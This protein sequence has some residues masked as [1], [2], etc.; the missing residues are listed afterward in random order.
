MAIFSLIL[1]VV[2]LLLMFPPSSS[3]SDVITHDHPLPDGR[4][5]V[6]K[7][8][9]FE[10]G[11]FS[12]GSST[13]RYV[14]IWYKSI[15][16]KTVVWVANRE[17]PV[18]DNSSVLS[19]NTEGRLVLLSQNQTIVWSANSTIQ[20][21]N[22][23]AQL[24][25][26]GNLVLRNEQDQNPQNYLWQS[27]DYP[28]D[29]FLPGMKIG[30]DLKTGLNRRLIA[31]RNWDD[32]SPGDFTCGIA[33]HATPELVMWNGSEEIQ[34]SSPWNGVRIGGKTTPLFQLQF[35]V[36][37]DEVVY[38]SN[39]QGKSVTTRVILNQTVYSR[40]RYIWVEQTKSWMIYSSVP[41]DKC[42]DYN[43]CGPNGNCIA[44]ESPRCQC[45]T[46]F[47]PKSPKKYDALDWTQGCVR[48][49]P[50][51]C[52]VKD[53]DGF[54]KFSGLKLPDTRTSWVNA[55]MTLWECKAKCWEICSCNAYAN[56]YITGGG[57]GCILWFGDL[58][59]LRVVTVPGQD[60]FIR[61]A[62]SDIVLE[63]AEKH[64]KKVVVVTT[65]TFT[66]VLLMLLAFFSIHRRNRKRREK[67][68]T[69]DGQEGEQ[70]DIELPFFDIA[71]IIRV[72]NDF[73]SD[74]KLGQGG[75]GSVY[76]GTLE[77][78][79]E[80]AVKRLSEGSRQGL[81][82]FKNEVIMCAKLQ[83]RNLV[84]VLGC[85]IQREE[86]ML[87]YEYMPNK[88]LDSILFDFRQS[89]SLNWPRRFRIIFGIARGLVYLHQDSRLRIIHRD[90]KA[91]NILLDKDLNPKI[92]DFGIARM[93][94]GDQME[95]NTKKVIGTYGYMAPEYAVHGIFSIKSDVFSFG[96]LLLEIIS[97]K[98]NQGASYPNYGFNLIS[99]AWRLWK[100]GNTKELIDACLGNNFKLSD[101]LR[102]I[103]VALLCVQLRPDDRPNMALVLVM[104]SSENALP[105]PKEPG[106]LLE[107][108]SAE[109][110]CYSSNEITLTLLQA[111]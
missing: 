11:F 67:I 73:S 107:R 32:P 53:K 100:E 59:D 17:K 56:L 106:F 68:L 31:W 79:Q 86:K 98:R 10:L 22:P 4:T 57:S 14:G 13:N 93:F 43:S 111:R 60:L 5:L 105:E 104:L 16:Q 102:C 26:S 20:G 55:S 39:L 83:H 35:V 108:P 52:R 24:L 46:G 42:D 61:M 44:S 95:G 34:R 89:E 58:I 62:Y 7:D 18:K 101:L 47:K 72:T 80:I 71:T 36:N 96:V 15:S 33:L 97:G 64:K 8:G 27:F 109:G 9:I 90:L 75:F 2:T 38:T 63:D 54:K 74:K 40:Q 30:W 3:A 88:S 77:D 12:L 51:H 66:L 65:V 110:E 94:G 25:D 49:E 23:I 81:K 82:E 87:I 92:S 37:E 45:L 6:S 91:S 76:R 70:E 78:G 21:L 29:T 99:H 48:S 103:H 84:K 69:E 1:A 50:W 85:C 28:S 19:V 41:S